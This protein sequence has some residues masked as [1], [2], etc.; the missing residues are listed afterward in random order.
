L[1]KK[2]IYIYIYI[3]IKAAKLGPA[4]LISDL[5]VVLAIRLSEFSLFNISKLKLIVFLL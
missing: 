4:S 3:Y 5:I 1:L 2:K